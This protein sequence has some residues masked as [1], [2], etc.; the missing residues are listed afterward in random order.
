MFNKDRDKK[1]YFKIQASSA[2]PATSAYS[3]HDVKRR[4]LEDARAE[5][6]RLSMARQRGRIRRSRA[7][8]DPTLS[9]LLAEKESYSYSAASQ[10]L[11]GGF[12]QD[13]TLNRT[14]IFPSNYSPLF[15][16]DP[17]FDIDP[18]LIDIRLGKSNSCLSAACI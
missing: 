10:A 17:R 9:R 8:D 5:A 18:S 11:V 2:A 13:G 15:D 16:V 6:S 12:L 14:T 7:V 3:S 1:K 4:Q